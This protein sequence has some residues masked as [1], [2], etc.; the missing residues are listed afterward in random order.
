MQVLTLIKHLDRSAVQPYLCL[1]DGEDETSRSLE[2]ADCPVMRLGSYALRSPKIVGAAIRFARFLRRERIDIL[3]VYFIQSATF[4]VTIG[5][6]A[7]TRHVLRVRNNIG[8]WVSPRMRRRFRWVNRLV[9]KVITNSEAGRSA[10]IG[11]EG[12]SPEAVIVLENGVDFTL[13]PKCPRASR[14]SRSGAK[15]VGVVANLRRV[16]GLD[17]LLRAAATI[18][19]TDRDVQFLI[20]GDLDGEDATRCELERLAC[21][22]G[23]SQSIH[24]LGRVTDVPSFLT[25]LDVATLC[26]RAEGTSNALIEYMAAGL[27]IVA[28]SVGGNGALIQDELD[29]ILV[30]PE[31]P[32]R[33]ASGILSLLQDPALSARLAEAAYHSIRR[34]YGNESIGKKYESFYRSLM[35]TSA[36]E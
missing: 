27:P 30:P 10:V 11:Q 5:R 1:L 8:H 36:H 29:G 15:R 7:G 32:D 16:K 33:L 31:D 20:A 12:I 26:S 3:Q 21:D 4:G 19:E 18:L 17:I 28:T 6:L 9:S 34:R 35:A 2:P 14:S 23:I 24:F 22:L 13:Y 25:T